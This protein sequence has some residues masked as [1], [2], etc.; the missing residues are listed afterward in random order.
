MKVQ[1]NL[2]ARSVTEKE[3]T[4]PRPRQKNKKPPTRKRVGAKHTPAEGGMEQ[5]GGKKRQP[6]EGRG[7]R[8][9]RS[10]N[11][12]ASRQE[13]GAR[14]WSKRTIEK[15]K[16]KRP[17]PKRNPGSHEPRD[18]Q[19]VA[20]KTTRPNASLGGGKKKRPNAKGEKFWQEGT[21]RNGPRCPGRRISTIKLRKQNPP[22]PGIRQTRSTNN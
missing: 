15:E 1:K 8:E 9:E 7:A 5:E 14:K 20:K 19:A 22:D 6:R 3:S 2:T 4:V 10:Q 16:R 17:R 18:F 12:S 13:K 11:L 21:A